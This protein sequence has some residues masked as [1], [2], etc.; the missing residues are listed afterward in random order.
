MMC[1]TEER[2]FRSPH[3]KPL[4]LDLTLPKC[5]AGISVHSSI[6]HLGTTCL[7]SVHF[8]VPI[9]GTR[10]E[11]ASRALQDPRVASF[12]TVAKIFAYC[13]C[14]ARM[15]RWSLKFFS[16]PSLPA[17]NVESSTQQESKSHHRKLPS[18]SHRPGHLFHVAK[19]IHHHERAAYMPAVV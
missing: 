15:C 7:K 11:P 14:S 9:G 18:R 6:C 5:G 17:A 2:F 16:L 10:T 12:Y 1:F 13:R 4:L 8:G 19:G 3:Q